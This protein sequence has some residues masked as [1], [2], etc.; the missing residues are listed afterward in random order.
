M[1]S[2]TAVLLTALCLLVARASAEEGGKTRVLMMTGQNNHKWQ[3]TTPVM[4]ELIEGAGRFELTVDKKPWELGADA[5][6]DCDVVLSNWSMW[7]KIDEDPWSD[8]V[9]Q[10][11]L[12][13]ISRGGGLVVVHAGSSIHYEWPEFQALVGRT[14]RNGK[15]GHGPKHEFE[16][17]AKDEHPITAGVGPFVIFDELWR[18]MDE[19]GP[20][21]VIATADTSRDRNPGDPAPILFT[22]KLGEGRGVNLVLGHDTRSMECPEWRELFLR[23][24][25]WAA[26]G[27][28]A[29]FGEPAEPAAAE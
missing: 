26:T 10:A 9:K 13:F 27:D 14:W 23:S 16:V 3:E 6:D 12:D 18:K 20:H 2:L 11:F 1:K 28:T 24:L 4:A 5:F 22:T 19:T 29:P 7:P 25:E 15:T 17:S 21:E 8:E